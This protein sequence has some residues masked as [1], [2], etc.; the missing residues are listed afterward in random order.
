[1]SNLNWCKPGCETDLL[2]AIEKLQAELPGWWWQVGSCSV[3]ADASIGPD[4]TGPDADLLEIRDFDE[5]IHNDLRHP[6]TTADALLGA[7][8]I[9]KEM[10]AKIKGGESRAET[11]GDR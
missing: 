8:A 3:S 2:D 9:A 5:G 6:A 1:M 7:I 11:H 4:R 10:R